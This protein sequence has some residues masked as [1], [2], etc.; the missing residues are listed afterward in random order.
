[1]KVVCGSVR[2]MRI[3]KTGISVTPGRLKII[4]KSCHR[5][6]SF[7]PGARLRSGRTVIKIVIDGDWRMILIELRFVCRDKTARSRINDVIRKDVVGHVPLHL[8]LA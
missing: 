5:G 6:G 7:S 4:I 1:M 8:E 2:K 3:E